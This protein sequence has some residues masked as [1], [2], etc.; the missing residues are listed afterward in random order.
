[1]RRQ[2]SIF[3]YEK[4]L[5]VSSAQFVNIVLAERVN[6][7]NRPSEHNLFLSIQLQFP[8]RILVDVI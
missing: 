3:M 5:M 6:G 2:C 8:K 7:E 1:M 4:Q